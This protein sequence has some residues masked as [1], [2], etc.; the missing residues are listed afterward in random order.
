[1]LTKDET[2]PD[3]VISGSEYEDDNNYPSHE[4]LNN[5]KSISKSKQVKQNECH[6]DDASCVE[7]V[8]DISEYNVYAHP[9]CAKAKIDETVTMDT[10]EIQPC[11]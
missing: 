7:D 6:G 10:K 4:W 9:I 8:S 2:K 11:F 1:M 5:F 3:F